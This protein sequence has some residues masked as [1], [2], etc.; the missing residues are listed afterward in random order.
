MLCGT[1]VVARRGDDIKMAK[2][3]I[4]RASISLRLSYSFFRRPRYNL[5][6]PSMRG[7]VQ[8]VLIVGLPATSG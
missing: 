3:H 6:K 8:R 2:W 7:P 4:P 5:I 1:E